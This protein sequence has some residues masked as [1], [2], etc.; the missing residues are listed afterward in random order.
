LL[1][2][3][4]SGYVVNYAGDSK[5]VLENFHSLGQKPVLI[6]SFISSTNIVAELSLF[7]LMMEFIKPFMPGGE[8][9]SKVQYAHLL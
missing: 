2:R 7:N 1:I 5:I 4:P 6:T 8:I 3:F 9:H